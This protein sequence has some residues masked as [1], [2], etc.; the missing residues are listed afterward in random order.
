MRLLVFMCGITGLIGAAMAGDYDHVNPYAPSDFGGRIFYRFDFN[1]EQKVASNHM[2]GFQVVNERAEFAG[3]PALL[4]T[5]F[6][7]T[8]Q[9]RFLISGLDITP[10]LLAARQN[11]SSPT[12]ILGTTSAA[13]LAAVLLMIGTGIYIASDP[14]DKDDTTTPAGTG[15]TGAGG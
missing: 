11:E 14:Q 5:E 9:P 3:A 1:G 8:T 7:S 6:G 12:G 4:R 10:M 15:G 2:L 13:E